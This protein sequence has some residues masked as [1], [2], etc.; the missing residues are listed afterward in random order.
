MC[1]Q[2]QA[3]PW[4]S[5]ALGAGAKLTGARASLV[6]RVGRPAE[7][8]AFGAGRGGVWWELANMVLARFVFV[9]MLFVFCKP[10]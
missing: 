10:R 2:Q 1:R 5:P 4:S 7:A 6:G 8:L 9:F 3:W